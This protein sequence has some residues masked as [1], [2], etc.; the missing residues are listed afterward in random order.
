MI[1]LGSQKHGAM[2]PLTE[3]LQC[4]DTGSLGKT[5]WEDKVEQLFIW[6]RIFG[7]LPADGDEP[8]KNWWV[9]IRE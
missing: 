3:M 6:N 9:K 7:V 1:L 5:G 8:A 4:R 2:D